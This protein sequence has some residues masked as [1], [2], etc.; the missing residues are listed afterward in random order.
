MSSKQDFILGL[1]DYKQKTDLFPHVEQRVQQAKEQFRLV[2]KARKCVKNSKLVFK[3][4][5]KD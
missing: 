2:K 4:Q 3:Q 1:E 5:T